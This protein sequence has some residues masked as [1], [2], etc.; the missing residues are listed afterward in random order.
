MVAVDGFTVD[1]AVLWWQEDQMCFRI[2]KKSLKTA[3]KSTRVNEK[4]SKQHAKVR[5]TLSSPDGDVP[6]ASLA[7]AQQCDGIAQDELHTRD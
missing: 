3:E 4:S 7:V 5:I 1:G 6:S 2:D